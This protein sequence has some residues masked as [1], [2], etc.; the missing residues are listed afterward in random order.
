MGTKPLPTDTPE[1]MPP[2]RVMALPVAERVTREE[3]STSPTLT[4]SVESP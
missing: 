2:A 4:T 3:T 1:T